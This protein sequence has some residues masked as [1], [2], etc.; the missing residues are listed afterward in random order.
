MVRVGLA[1]Y[2]YSDE[3]NIKPALDLKTKVTI[4]KNIKAGTSVSYGATWTAKKDCTIGIIPIGYA[5]GYM[6]LLSN[7]AKVLIDNVLCDVI[8]N[9]C[10]D[11]TAILLPDNF[12]TLEKDVLVFGNNDELNA[13]SLAR[14]V[15]T[16]N[17]EILTSIAQRVP[18][19]YNINIYD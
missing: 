14:I 10:M 9:I 12:D 4:I 17:Y 6:R 5:D 18:R 16:I 19:I 8:G 15:G 7:K 13:T 1:A 3:P 11:Q 2:G